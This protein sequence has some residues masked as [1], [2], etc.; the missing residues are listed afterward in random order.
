MAKPT[1]VWNINKKYW[2]WFQKWA[3]E[4]KL[5]IV[6]KSEENNRY[7]VTTQKA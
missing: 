5:A 2:D 7:L 1:K 4:Q 6:N 3:R